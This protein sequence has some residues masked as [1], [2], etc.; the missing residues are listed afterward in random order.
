M[1]PNFKRLSQVLTSCFVM[2]VFFTVPLLAQ[3][4][5]SQTPETQKEPAPKIQEAVE[6]F[7]VER[8]PRDVKSKM[9][10]TARRV[11]MVSCRKSGRKSKMFSCIFTAC[12]SKTKIFSQLLLKQSIAPSTC[13]SGARQN[14]RRNFNCSIHCSFTTGRKWCAKVIMWSLIFCGWHPRQSNRLLLI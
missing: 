3:E 8:I 13:S 1:S 9:P 5:E 6:I 10:K 14:A 7:L 11:F 2:S 4:P 12:P